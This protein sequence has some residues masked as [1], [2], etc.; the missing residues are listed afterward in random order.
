MT[1]LACYFHCELTHVLIQM[2]SV[3]RLT[4][5]YYIVDTCNESLRFKVTGMVITGVVIIGRKE[6]S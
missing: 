4:H 1:L 5:H 6:N 2:P 3:M